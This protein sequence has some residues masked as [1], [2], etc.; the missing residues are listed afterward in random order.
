MLCNGFVLIIFS[1]EARSDEGECRNRT[2]L[3]LQSKP[4]YSRNNVNND[5]CKDQGER[6]ENHN[7]WS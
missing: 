6:F 1:H 4:L 2:K 3:A 7:I 5:Y